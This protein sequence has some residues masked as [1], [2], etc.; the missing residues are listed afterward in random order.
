[1]SRDEE[2][3]GTLD[4]DDDLFDFDELIEGAESV[5]DELTNELDDALGGTEAGEPMPAPER[6]AAASDH[7]FMQAESDM[8]PEPLATVAPV[9]AATAHAAAGDEKRVARVPIL[10]ACLVVLT[11]ANVALV[12]LTWK[13]LDTTQDLIAAGNAPL[14]IEREP[15][16]ALTPTTGEPGPTVT[17]SPELPLADPPLE[18]YATLFEA[19]TALGRGE[20]RRARRA[21]FGLLAVIDRVPAEERADVEAKAGFLVAETYRLQ[22]RDS[23]QGG[24]S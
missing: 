1:M 22:A 14:V 4:D 17:S 18:A 15:A 16:P 10:A 5:V 21:L 19:E 20:F 7:A 8:T 13:S 12:G 23:V 2:L 3:Q 11:L 9:P 6:F 24:Q